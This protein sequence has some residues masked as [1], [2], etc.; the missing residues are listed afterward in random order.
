MP[1]SLLLAPLLQLPKETDWKIYVANPVWLD[2]TGVTD[3][4]YGTLANEPLLSFQR[5]RKSRKGVTM[6]MYH[7][8]GSDRRDVDAWQVVRRSD[9]L[10]QVEYIRRHYDLVGI[11]QAVDLQQ[12]GQV[13]RSKRPLAVLTFDDGHRGNFEFLLPIVEQEAL[14]V[15]LYIA[16]G[17]IESGTGYWFDRIVNR[18]QSEKPIKLDLRAHGLGV[19]QF[20]DRRG[21]SNWSLIQSLLVA[22][23]SGSPER[24]ELIAD[25]IIRKLPSGGEDLLRPLQIDE[26]KDLSRCKWITLGAHTHGHEVLTL[27]DASTAKESIEDSIS[28]LQGWTGLTPK[29]FAYPAGYFNTELMQL[30]RD[31]GFR[32]AATTEPGIWFSDQSQ[33][34][35]PR[36]SVGRYDSFS[37]FKLFSSSLLAA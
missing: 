8:I 30:V 17:H 36:I 27:L 23:K 9:F 13:G 29:H 14:P 20:N 18:L 16:T 32:S 5:L 21:S 22:I 26:L 31:L 6:F 19:R 34:A 24:C 3:F 33:Y 10:R 25:E 28:R 15:T 37:K 2:M 12:T 35:I 4:I 7:D 1:D 11:D